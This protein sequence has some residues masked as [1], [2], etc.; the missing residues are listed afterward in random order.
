[1]LRIVLAAAL[2]HLAPAFAQAPKKAVAPPAVQKEFDGFIGTFRAALKANDS[3]AVAGMTRLPF[4][5]DGA[6]LDAAQ[7]REKIYERDFTAKNRACLQRGKAFYNHD[8]EDNENFFIFCGNQI[9]V[10]TKTRAGFL[11]TDGGMRN[12]VAEKDE[13]NLSLS[14]WDYSLFEA[15]ARV[16]PK[17]KS[18]INDCIG[19]EIEQL[20]RSRSFKSVD[21]A[22]ESVKQAVEQTCANQEQVYREALIREGGNAS[23]A[24]DFTK[25]W[26]HVRIADGLSCL[27]RAGVAPCAAAQTKGA[28]TRQGDKKRSANQEQN[29][30]AA[31]P[32]CWRGL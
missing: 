10:F 26:E 7:F 23:Q 31:S 9:F 19:N 14:A 30:A 8:D 15:A 27:S 21:R 20:G 24:R 28:R 29:A 2:L 6:T 25:M 12:D 13:V 17:D 32:A 18:Q 5:N 16:E 22:V 11:F 4:M 1:M 3:A